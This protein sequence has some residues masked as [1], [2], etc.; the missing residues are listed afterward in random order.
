ML[1]T[2]ASRVVGAGRRQARWT[3]WTALATAVLF[4][5]GLVALGVVE[6]DKASKSTVAAGRT[7]DPDSGIEPE[8]AT[9]TPVG[10]PVEPGTGQPSTIDPDT[11]KP[12]AA[13]SSRAA[14]RAG[15]T[16]IQPA[17]SAS[18]IPCG[19]LSN[20]DQ[21]VTKDNV[22]I[23][24]LIPNL[25]ELASAGFRV[26]VPGDHR[27]IAEAWSKEGGRL[28]ALCG[29]KVTYVAEVFSVF[30]VDEMIADC[31]KL[32]E[33][34]KV[35]TVFNLGGYDS[36]GQLCIA[37]EHKTP[38]FAGDP[39]PEDW[40]AQSAPYLWTELI[41]KDRMHKNHVRY[42]AESGDIKPSHVVGLVYHGIPNVGP[43]VER[44][45][46]TEMKKHGIT[47]KV[48]AKLSDDNNQAVN[49][50]N[51]VV[52]EMNRAGVN[53]VFMPM[54]LIFKTQFMQAAEGQN[55]YPRYTDSD[56][57]FGCYDFV[58]ATYPAQSFDKTKCVTG[59]YSG[60]D[61]P[62]PKLH[63]APQLKDKVPF[64]NYCDE[65]YKRAFPA[66]YATGGG[67]DPNNQEAQRALHCAFGSMFLQWYEAASRVGSD[68]TRPKWGAEME[69]TGK[70]TRTLGAPW[71]EYRK[72]KYD[73]PVLLAVVEWHAAPD[74]N[75]EERHYHQILK[76][77]PAYYP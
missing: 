20:S 63:M 8:T 72:G 22:K 37:K 29:R 50:I 77:F 75:R 58:T 27:R 44:S 68:L 76:H 39:Q 40:Y 60:I 61:S 66:G 36:I 52:L 12:V 43:A 53:Y 65:V 10:A 33:D 28:N 6:D 59:T 15:S 41:N 19:T 3:Q 51:Q 46:L 54:N 14:Q 23:G 70:W 35:F 71:M 55:W 7:A 5:A 73:G 69:K 11:G 30:D 64:L 74:G 26:G 47:P 1:P 13:G 67:D 34:E 62:E 56:H 48:V 16:G 45:L 57:Y 9:T 32:T 4:F 38:L 17:S 21:G 42:L 25:N 31:K 18:K 49:Q 2:Q 24:V